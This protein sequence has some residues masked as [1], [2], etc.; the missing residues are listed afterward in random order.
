M[1]GSS[2]DGL[3]IAFVELEESFGK[4]TFTIVEAECIPYSAEWEQKLRGAINLSARDYLLLDAEYG[5]YIGKTVSLFMDR[6][7]LGY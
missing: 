1:S 5:H 6:H 3:D 4:W 2:L 7:Q